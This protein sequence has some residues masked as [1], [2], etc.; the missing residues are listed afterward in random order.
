[1]VAVTYSQAAQAAGDLNIVVVGWSDSTANVSSVADTEGNV[2]QLAVGPTVVPG[3]FSQAIYYANGIKAANAG[4]NVVTVRFN[5]PATS[6]DIRILE[7]SGIDAANP[8]DVTAANSDAITFS[9]TLPSYTGIVTTTHAPDLLLAANTV[10]G[11]TSGPGANFTQRILTAP[12]GNLVEDRVVTVPGVFS[13]SSAS[14][15]ASDQWVM[16]MVAFRAATSQ[17]PDTTPPTVSIVPPTGTTGTITVTVSA[18]DTGT[19]VAGVQ[20]QV[21]GVPFGTAATASPY[22]FSLN[23][24]TFANGTHTLTASATDFANNTGFA[25]SVQVTFNSTGRPDLFGL[26]SDVITLP[27]VTVNSVLL[28]NGKILFWDGEAF[29]ATAIVWNPTM[30]TVDWVPAPVDIFCTGNEQLADGRII[31]VGG[32]VADHVGLPA[33]NIFD[34][35]TDS[36]T[37]LPNMAFSRW[38]PTATILPDGR[39]MVTSGEQN[40]DGS[41]APIEDIYNPSTNSWS[42]LNSAPFPYDY[43]YPH[44]FVLP[45]GRIL[46]AATTQYP[47][48]SQ[49]LDLS[50]STWTGVGGAAENGG[51]SVMY[52]PYKFL[53]M[54]HYDDA[55][56]VGDPSVATAYVLDMSKTSPAWRQVASMAFTRT[57]HNSTLLPDGTVLVTGGGTT[58]TSG[59]VADA[60][61]P[62]ELWSPTSE[63]WMTLASMSVPRLYHSEA[64]LLPDGR[65]LISGGGRFNSDNESVYQYSAQFYSPPYLFK[66][67]GLRPTIASA[68]STLS[69]G[70]N[71]TVVT[72]NAAQIA[73]VSLIRFGSVT[74]DINMSQR[75]L[76]LSFVVGSGSLT[77]TAPVDANLAP[78]GNYLLFIVDSSG[79]PSVAAVVH[80]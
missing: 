29:G 9:S 44:N 49:V 69:Y 72:P 75:F 17:L 27:I 41:D 74:H 39:V 3:A 77:V 24:A 31:V 7:Y 70:Q 45:D 35:T 57:Y 60:V 56:E 2:Y 20:L 59:D 65:V 30:N 5:S 66:N 58:T 37:V 34:S 36:W 11:E 67:S 22:T 43:Y 54:G 47:I 25:N 23:T 38:Y 16:Q 71:F 55:D 63:T 42:Q 73:Q 62:A 4:A 6:P 51:S 13:A 28:P 8:V 48:V 52:L 46:A 80:F 79:V 53:K 40:G 21:D 12:D 61:L 10:A 15:N 78:P 18:S 19:G 1:M 33:A 26:W 50:A 14:V 32:T 76:P 68:P 64:L